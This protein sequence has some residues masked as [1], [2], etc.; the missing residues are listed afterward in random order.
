MMQA[1]LP[2]APAD[3]GWGRGC[4]DGMGMGSGPR[5]HARG[6]AQAQWCHGDGDQATAGTELGFGSAVVQPAAGAA[7][8]G[9]RRARLCKV[10]KVAQSYVSTTGGCSCGNCRGRPPRVGHPA[11]RMGTRRRAAHMAARARVRQAPRQNGAAGAT[12]H[13]LRMHLRSSRCHARPNA[14][15]GLEARPNARQMGACAACIHAMAARSALTTH[16]AMDRHLRGPPGLG[17]RA[18]ARAPRNAS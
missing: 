17:G 16:T 4:G 3:R 15:F 10:G 14:R 7:T 12:P 18:P 2:L 9:V 6:C 1:M 11:A 5:A 8:M 13:A